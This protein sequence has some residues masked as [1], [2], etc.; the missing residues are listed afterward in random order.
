MWERVPLCLYVQCGAV[1]A[2]TVAGFFL[3]RKWIAGGVCTSQTH[4]S[5]KTVLITGANTGIGK[6]TAQ[7]M[8]RRGARVVMACR[9]LRRADMAVQEI[10]RATGNGNVVIRH[11]N[12][13]SLYSIHEFA[14]EFLATEERLDILINNA[15]VMMCP[16]WI[17]EDGFETQLAVNHLGHFLLTNLLLG[18]LKSSAPS[19]VV[20]VSCIAHV[21][22]KIHI[23]DLFFDKRP[24]NSLDSYRQSKLANVLFSK[25]L[26][27]RMKGTGMTSYSLHPGVIH[28]ELGRHVKS[29]YPLLSSVQS[30]VS[31]LLTKTPWQGAQTSIY[32][33][34]TEGLEDKSGCYFSD[35]AE[36]EPAPEAKDDEVAQRLWDESARLVGLTTVQ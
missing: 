30:P 32:C 25:E 26:A 29:Q 24:Y 22:G 27:Q 7:D 16:K 11:L 4:L 1:L 28:T 5:G 23:D 33:A 2:L 15:G 13:A 34:V 36:K 6:E 19:R 35:C 10:R 18:I 20:N 31:F 14:K 17:T 12:L 21:G 8:A 9:D 3:M